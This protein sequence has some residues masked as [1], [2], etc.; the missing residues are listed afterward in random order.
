MPVKNS[1]SRGRPESRSY[2]VKWFD[3]WDEFIDV[4]TGPAYQFWAFRGHADE[5]WPI[6]STLARYFQ[7]FKINPNA[8]A[9]MEEV[10]IRRFKRKAHLFLSHVPDWEDDFQWIALMQHHGA[11]TRMVDLTWSP[12]VAAFFALERATKDAAVWALNPA[13]IGHGADQKDERGE[14]LFPRMAIWENGAFNKYLLC[15]S[16]PFVVVGEPKIMNMRLIAQAG[17]FIMPSTL[18]QPIEN[19]LSSYSDTQVVKFVLSNKGVRDRGMSELFHMNISAAT[20]F[21]GLDGMARS[22]A[23]EL[24]VHHS[25]NPKAMESNPDFER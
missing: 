11:P 2:E 5:S 25:F 1:K 18:D 10:I 20:L 12:Y 24:E 17:T 21:P 4:I 14:I 13:R 15:A 8:W 19:I 22:L 3:S 23:Y 16:T 6:H 9:Y 7:D